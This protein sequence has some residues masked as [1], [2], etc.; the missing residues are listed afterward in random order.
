MQKYAFF[1]ESAKYLTN[2]FKFVTVGLFAYHSSLTYYFSF[3]KT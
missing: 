1:F 3:E 2:Y